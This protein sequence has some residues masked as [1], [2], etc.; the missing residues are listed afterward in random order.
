MAKVIAEGKTIEV[1]DGENIKPACEDIGVPFGCEDGICGVCR[2]EVTKGS[3]N[4]SEVTE[5]ERNF[6]CNE[7]NRLACQCVLKK[8]VLEFKY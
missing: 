7:T 5:A 4:L 6:D 8:G 2:I 3:E 1:K